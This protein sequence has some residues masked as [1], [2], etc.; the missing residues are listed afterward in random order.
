M[1]RRWAG[2][3]PLPAFLW[4]LLGPTKKS[5]GAKGQVLAPVMCHCPRGSGQGP[6]DPM[7]QQGADRRHFRAPGDHVLSPCQQPFREKAEGRGW[8]F[9]TSAGHCTLPRTNCPASP[10]SRASQFRE[11]SGHQKCLGSWWVGCPSSPT[12]SLICQ[13]RFFLG[14]GFREVEGGNLDESLWTR[15]VPCKGAPVWPWKVETGEFGRGRPSGQAQTLQ[16]WAERFD[17]SVPR[18]LQASGGDYCQSLRTG[19]PWEDSN[20]DGAWRTVS[21][22]NP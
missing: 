1:A 6:V 12:S 8:S 9:S 11:F 17:H 18:F 4:V 22:R 21:S 5:R 19:M 14:G 16:P 2:S 15:P 20:A 13:G 10:P 7:A 3:F